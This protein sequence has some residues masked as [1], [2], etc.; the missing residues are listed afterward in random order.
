LNSPFLVTYNLS[1]LGKKWV[2]SVT[3]LPLFDGACERD[4]LEPDA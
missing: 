2:R 3:K 4:I 1:I